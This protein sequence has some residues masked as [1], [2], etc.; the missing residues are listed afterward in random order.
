MIRALR[1]APGMYVIPCPPAPELTLAEAR[2]EV[3]CGGDV[4]DENGWRLDAPTALRKPTCR[5]AQCSLQGDER[6]E[7]RGAKPLWQGAGGVP[8][9]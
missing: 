1:R 8:Q 5:E 6:G 9:I 3:N 4:A 2:Y 7:S